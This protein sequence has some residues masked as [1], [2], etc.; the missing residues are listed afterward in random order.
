[1]RC[2]VMLDCEPSQKAAGD[3]RAIHQCQTILFN[4]LVGL[5]MLQN[6]IQ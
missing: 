4:S 2:S 3:L 5:K 6:N 1:M